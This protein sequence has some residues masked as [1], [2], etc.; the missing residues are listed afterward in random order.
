MQEIGEDFVLKFQ[1]MKFSTFDFHL[2]KASSLFLMAI[3]TTT[4]RMVAVATLAATTGWMKFF[5]SGFPYQFNAS[6]KM[7][8]FSG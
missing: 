8:I 3:T 1:S 2:E 6:D 5:G 4:I 7:E